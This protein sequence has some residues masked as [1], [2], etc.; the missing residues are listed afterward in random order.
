M[1][2][3]NSDIY[4]K[5]VSGNIIISQGQ[6]GG[7]TAHDNIIGNSKPKGISFFKKKYVIIIGLVGSVL[8]ILAYFGLQPAFKKDKNILNHMIEIYKNDTAKTLN[9]N[10]NQ[11]SLS[12]FVMKKG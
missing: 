12:K 6:K 1:K 9:G 7:V 2:K 4:V 10:P 5:K 11:N 8:T 3:K